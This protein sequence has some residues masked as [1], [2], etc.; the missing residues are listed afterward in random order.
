MVDRELDKIT[1]LF[2]IARMTTAEKD[3]VAEAMLAILVLWHVQS[4]NIL[5]GS[6]EAVWSTKSFSTIK[7]IDAVQRYAEHVDSY[8]SDSGLDL[9]EVIRLLS[10]RIDRDS[11]LENFVLS[12]TDH[13]QY[14]LS[15][16]ENRRLA[17]LFE[18]MRAG[19]A[20][21]AGLEG[22]FTT[23]AD[24]AK[25]MVYLVNPEPG[26]TVFDPVCGSGQLLLQAA[27]YLEKAGYDPCEAPLLGW[28]R[29]RNLVRITKWAFLINGLRPSQVNCL[30]AFGTQELPFKHDIALANPPF[31]T[32]D[33]DREAFSHS[34]YS[35]F[36]V[37]P[38][39]NADFAFLQIAIGALKATGKGVVVVPSGMLFRRGVEGE[40]RERIVAKGLIDMVISLPTS[41][42]K[43]RSVSLNLLVID[44]G[45]VDK[46][47]LF[48]DG[49]KMFED[50]AAEGG[51]EELGRRIRDSQLGS[52]KYSSF[53]RK[54]NYIEIEQNSFDLTVTRYLGPDE[55]E[56]RELK[57]IYSEYVQET[58]KLDL[59]QKE[60]DFYLV[61]E[62]L[63]HG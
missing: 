59:L 34:S 27:K 40:I 29:S 5:N 4:H 52:D 18:Y 35:V 21:Q 57:T 14:I 2:R 46:S 53:V 31:S 11:A 6:I 3:L 36:G 15:S 19:L 42:Q 33:W 1:E 32:A 60:F 63:G 39:S 55:K 9:A 37:P 28:D 13:L 44:K 26:Q 61:E 16:W 41:S 58:K 22:V 49:I 12:V 25:L 30:D 56:L 38:Q 54:V 48:V 51:L 7:D 20:P 47:I 43:P 24:L 62:D 10:E 50:G 8:F 23:P 17:E 45:K